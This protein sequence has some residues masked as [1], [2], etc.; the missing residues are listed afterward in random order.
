MISKQDNSGYY[1]NSVTSHISETIWS[2]IRGRGGFYDY[3]KHKR[4]G[5]VCCVLYPHF[6]NIRTC[7]VCQRFIIFVALSIVVQLRR[8]SCV[9]G[10]YVHITTCK[11]LVSKK[12]YKYVNIASFESAPLVY[13]PNSLTI[14]PY[15]LIEQRQ[16]TSIYINVFTT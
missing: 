14:K 7:F 8:F 12:T 5:T 13:H 1:L 16:Y 9:W 11:K 10:L 2:K 4:D 6:G 15:V 3:I